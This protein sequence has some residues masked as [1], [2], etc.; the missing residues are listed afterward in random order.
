MNSKPSAKDDVM[1]ASR[2]QGLIGFFGAGV[3]AFGL[4]YFLHLKNPTY[5][6]RFAPSAK[7]GLP[8]MVSM[9]VGSVLFE[10]TMFDA[11]RNPQN[12]ENGELKAVPAAPHKNHK[13]IPIHHWIMNRIHD[14]PFYFSGM[15]AL[16]VA[17]TILYTRMKEPHLTFSQAL[18]QT[19]VVS[20][21][22]SSF[23][24]IFPADGSIRYPCHCLD[25]PRSEI[26]HRLSWQISRRRRI[27]SSSHRYLD[28]G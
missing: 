7:V 17:G 23:N 9:F 15:M 3:P 6:N 8:L 11:H 18:L 16:P 4:S 22:F 21:F 26:L 1:A 12:Y 24:L 19:R 5:R 25:N 2:N 20:F 13:S 14:S 27:N 28:I 10:L